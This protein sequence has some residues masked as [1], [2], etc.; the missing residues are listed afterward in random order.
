MA[1]FNRFEEIKSWEKSQG[2]AVEIYGIF[3]NIKDFAF[4]DQI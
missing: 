1:R 4:K 3:K 2:L